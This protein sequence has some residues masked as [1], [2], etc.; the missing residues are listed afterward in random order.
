MRLAQASRSTFQVGG[1]TTVVSGSSTIS[2]PCSAPF[3]SI[4][5]RTRAFIMP[6]AG[7]KYASRNL[8]DWCEAPSGA[9]SLA[10][11]SAKRT[12]DA[13]AMVAVGLVVGAREKR[14]EFRMQIRVRYLRRKRQGHFVHLVAILE[15]DVLL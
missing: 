2:G 4:R 1:T 3:M 11:R 9:S 13:V 5:R 14:R 15:V 6:R 10:A 7:P 8:S 12:E